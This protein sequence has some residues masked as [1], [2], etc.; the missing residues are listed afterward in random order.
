MTFLLLVFFVSTMNFSM[1]EGTLDGALPKD[2]G[3][4]DC[5][6]SGPR[7][8]LVL[9]VADPGTLVASGTRG[10]AQRLDYRG[11][12]IRIE[13]GTRTFYLHPDAIQDPRN[14]I[15]ELS[16]F[17]S[18]WEDLQEIPC[19]IDPRGGTTYGDVLPVFD[20]VSRLGMERITFAGTYEQ[21]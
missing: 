20:L 17:L 19:T 10:S 15:P 5:G 8:D 16:A 1:L 12:R 13:V 21:N 7:I 4:T 6:F 18:T 11:R 14:P 3:T 9:F 2:R